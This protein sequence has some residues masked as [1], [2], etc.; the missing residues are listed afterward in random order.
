[1]AWESFEADGDGFGVFVQRFNADAQPVTA[2]LLAN[3]TAAGDQAAPVVATDAAGN[4]LLVW[5]SKEQDGDGWGIYGRWYAP[6]GAPAGDEFLVNAGE[7]SGQS[8]TAGD[9]Q[10]PSVAMSASGAAMDWES[11]LA[12]SPTRAT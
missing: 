2:K 4:T 9:Q 7:L 1:M 11:S 3:Q 5:A 6:D 12:C 8:L 10:A